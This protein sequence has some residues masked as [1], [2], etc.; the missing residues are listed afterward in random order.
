MV[1]RFLGDIEEIQ[2]EPISDAVDLPFEPGCHF[3]LIL[4]D[5]GYSIAY[6]DVSTIEGA[7]I[8][9]DGLHY[10]VTDGHEIYLE[11]SKNIFPTKEAAIARREELIDAMDWDDLYASLKCDL[12]THPKEWGALLDKIRPLYKEATLGWALERA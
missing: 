6:D 4:E 3:W 1:K 11:S 7:L 5:S 8:R 9:E 10:L 2:N 12:K